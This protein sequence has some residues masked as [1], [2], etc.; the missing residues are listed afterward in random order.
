MKILPASTNNLKKAKNPTNNDI[1]G[2]NSNNIIDIKTKNL[3]KVKVNEVF[4]IDFFIFKVWIAFCQLQKIYT[5]TLI[6]YYFNPNIGKLYSGQIYL[7]D[8]GFT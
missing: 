7:V 8:P 4:K 3:L 5:K 1:A 6:L 2:R